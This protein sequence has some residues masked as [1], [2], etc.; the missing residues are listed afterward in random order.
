MVR[1]VFRPYTQIWRVICT[2]TALRASIKISPDFTLFRHSSPSFGSYQICS[3]S[4]PS[5]RVGRCWTFRCTPFTFIPRMSFSTRTLAYRVDSLVR[6]S[7]RDSKNHLRQN[8]NS[9]S[10]QIRPTRLSL[11]W[12]IWL[13]FAQHFDNGYR[14]S[15]NTNHS[16][17]Q[18]LPLPSQR[19]QIFSLSFQSPFHLSFT[20][21]VRYRSPIHI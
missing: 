8:H 16:V 2:S 1:L 19:F 3:Y 15:P 10:S 11:F 17:R 18:F 12:R 21:L 14:V 20:V 9:P 7:R 5:C 13:H 6:V 4:N